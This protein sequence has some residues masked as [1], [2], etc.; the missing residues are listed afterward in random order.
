MATT[1]TWFIVQ[2]GSTTSIFK[3]PSYGVQHFEQTYGNSIIYS[4]PS[5]A[6]CYDQ[7]WLED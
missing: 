4:G 7:M 5:L 3:V 2:I 6:H 1:F